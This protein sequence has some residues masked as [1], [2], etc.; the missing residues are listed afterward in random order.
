MVLAAGSLC[1]DSSRVGVID[2]PCFRRIG[3]DIIN[4]F[5]NTRDGTETVSH[6]AGSAGFLAYNTE[7]QRNLFVLFAHFQ[8][9]LANLCEGKINVC[10]GFLGFCSGKINTFR[11]Q[12]FNQGLT[13]GVYQLQTV[14]INVIKNQLLKWK[15]VQVS[16]QAL[17][18][19]RSMTGAAA[20]DYYF[21]TYH[22][23]FPFLMLFVAFFLD[24]CCTCILY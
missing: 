23:K 8:A 2:D 1:N 21:K 10:K 4:H 16:D 24:F 19:T 9:A 14:R 12:L 7:L 5:E 3:S 13:K 22:N 15:T 17:D 6:S 20:N 18:N 11:I